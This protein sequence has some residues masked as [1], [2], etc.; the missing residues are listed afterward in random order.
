MRFAGRAALFAG[1]LCSGGGG[2]GA[3]H[4]VRRPVYWRRGVPFGFR[5]PAAPARGQDD[6]TLIPVDFS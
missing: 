6:P 5:G 2:G 4:G 3:P 1:T